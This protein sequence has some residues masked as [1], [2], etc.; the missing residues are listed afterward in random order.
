MPEV[1][2]EKSGL[3]PSKYYHYACP[4]T[5]Y[6]SS[7]RKIK[8]T[9]TASDRYAFIHLQT[10]SSAYFIEFRIGYMSCRLLYGN[11]TPIFVN[12]S[13]LEIYIGALDYRNVTLMQPLGRATISFELFKDGKTA[14]TEEDGVKIL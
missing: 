11:A 4:I 3:F 9:F 13:L 7:Y 1:T 10:R 8:I 2:P 12:E 14:P 6:D 5:V